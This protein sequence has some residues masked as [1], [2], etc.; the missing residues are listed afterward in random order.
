MD[1]ET[2]GVAR[3]SVLKTI[4][5]TVADF[6]TDPKRTQYPGIYEAP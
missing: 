3:M 1:R 5:K 6:L 4:A 2:D